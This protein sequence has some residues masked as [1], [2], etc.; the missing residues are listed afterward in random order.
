M[1]TGEDASSIQQRVFVTGEKFWVMSI[2]AV[3]DGVVFRFCS[4][5]YDDVRYWGELKVPFPKGSVPPVSEFLN[6]VAEAVTV[7]PDENAAAPEQQPA[8]P[9]RREAAQPAPA[10]KPLAPIPPPP[11]P[12]PDEPP[13]KTIS[14][15]QTKDE[16]LATFGQPQRIFNLGAKQIFY[17]SDMKVTLLNGKVSDVAE[18]TK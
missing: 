7:Q 3:K 17:Y 12:P 4:D 2:T 15:G 9:A 13:T 6:T 14:L 16:V 5:P 10:E 8:A 1:H 11:P 18:V